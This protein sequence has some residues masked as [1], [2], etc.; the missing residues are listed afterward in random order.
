LPDNK[1][2]PNVLFDDQKQERGANKSLLT[3]LR[4]KASLVPP[5]DER[6]MSLDASSRQGCE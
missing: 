5:D 6:L 3:N 1:P 4:I 2:D